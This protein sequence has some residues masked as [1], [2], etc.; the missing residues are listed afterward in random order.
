MKSGVT[1]ATLATPN[2]PITP[3]RATIQA[4]R[5]ERSILTET[6]RGLTQPN[7]VETP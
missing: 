4:A 7:I 3:V 5:A 6:R 1:S 2:V